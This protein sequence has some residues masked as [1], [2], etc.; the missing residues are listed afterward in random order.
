MKDMGV[1]STSGTQETKA[2]AY[3][4]KAKVAAEEV[5]KRL[6]DIKKSAD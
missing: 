5:D 4:E 3:M 6:K 1:D 2:E